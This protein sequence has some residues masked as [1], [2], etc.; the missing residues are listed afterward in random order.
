MIIDWLKNLNDSIWEI[1]FLM[2]M[3]Y[4]DRII[5]VVIFVSCLTGVLAGLLL[6]GKIGVLDILVSLSANY[7]LVPIPMIHPTIHYALQVTSGLIMQSE[8]YQNVFS[9]ITGLYNLTSLTI[10]KHIY[11]A[12]SVLRRQLTDSDLGKLF[13]GYFN[14][15]DRCLGIIGQDVTPLLLFSFLIIVIIAKKNKKSSIL[16]VT[17]VLL[18]YKTLNAAFYIS[19]ACIAVTVVC[20][21]CSQ[22]QLPKWD[23][24]EQKII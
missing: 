9:Q 17:A 18:L 4:T 23:L 21:R 13:T 20:I 6:K 16:I 8:R 7:A 2:F 11:Q 12:D 24:K 14:A 19:E 1:I 15:E 10:A 22:S 5:L 3:P